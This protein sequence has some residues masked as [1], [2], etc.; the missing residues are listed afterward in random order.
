MN[1]VKKNRFKLLIVILV[2]I[3]AAHVVVF[4]FFVFPAAKPAPLPEIVAPPPPE[5]PKFRFR[6]PSDNPNFGLPFNYATAVDGDLANLPLSKGATSGFMVDMNTRNVLWMKNRNRSVPIASMVK[7]MTM[8]VT[9]EALEE[10]PE[11]SLDMPVQVTK[12]ATQVARTG[13]IWLDTRETISLRNLLQAV[14]IKSA[15]DAAYQVGE[16]IGGGD[17]N[18]FIAKMN[19]RARELGMPGTSFVNTNG[20][21]NKSGKDSLSTTEGMVILGERLLEYPDVMEW[22][23]TQQT[24]IERQVGKI[25]KTELTSTN[26]LVNPRYPGVDGLK[27]GYTKAAGCC[28]TFSCLRNG[29][30]IIGAITGFSSS[31][32]RDNFARKLLDWGYERAVA[33][34]SGKAEPPKAAPVTTPGAKKR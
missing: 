20:L 3:A 1:E 34:E 9:M 30:R 12:G 27:T 18:S 6:R 23:G 17:I 4:K 8:L 7:M 31:R 14:A 13:V 32:D 33:I 25:R 5:P 24:F 28:L 15:N 26:R 16:V 2:I 10:H 22:A 19:Q 11:W 21:P 29:R